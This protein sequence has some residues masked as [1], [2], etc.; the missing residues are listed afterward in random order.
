MNN[1]SYKQ[2]LKEV[3]VKLYDIFAIYP[4]RLNIEACPCCVTEEEQKSIYANS[5]NYLT[6]SQLS[7]FA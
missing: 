6:S 7:P 4:L 5:L 2:E 1:H 3:I